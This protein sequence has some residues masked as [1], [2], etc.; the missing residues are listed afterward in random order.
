VFVGS[1][2]SL[3]G[4]V[5]ALLV[6]LCILVSGERPAVRGRVGSDAPPTE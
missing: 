3:V 1:A 2:F 6:A 4:F 5:A